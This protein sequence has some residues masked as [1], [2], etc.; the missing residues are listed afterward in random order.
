MVTEY[1]TLPDEAI[2]HALERAG[3]LPDLDLI[4]TCLDRKEELTPGLRRMLV[5]PT[6]DSWDE[7]DPRWYGPIHAGLLLIAYRDLPALG[8]IAEMLRSDDEGTADMALEWFAHDLDAYGPQA[9]PVVIDLINA[10]YVSGSEAEYVPAAMTEVLVDIAREYP[11]EQ[12]RVRAALR[13]ALPHLEPDGALALTADEREHPK[14]LWTWVALALADLHDDA[15]RPQIV[16]LYAAHLIDEMVMGDVDDC[17]AILEGRRPSLPRPSRDILDLYASLH[18]QAVHDREWQGRAA[19]L[20]AKTA[21]PAVPAPSGRRAAGG[22]APAALSTSNLPYVRSEPKI[23]RND[24][25][26]C[27][28]GKKYKR[29]HG[30]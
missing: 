19:E 18:Q 17:L 3:R 26:P 5:Q 22:A 28:S 10:P 4:R 9:I 7:D 23:G 2:L 16:A 1:G 13:A 12:E 25:C 24:P 20:K 14:D 30:R 27:G 21:Q 29:C 8:L 11:E 15:S 6:D